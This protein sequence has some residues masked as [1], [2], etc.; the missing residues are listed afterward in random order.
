MSDKKILLAFYSGVGSTRTIAEVL[1]I[2]L[3]DHN[4]RI[5]L[6]DID[7]NTDASIIEKYDFLIIGTPTHHCYPP[8]T[9]SEFIDKIGN[10]SKPINIFLFATYGLYVGNNL[11]KIAKSLLNKNIHTVGFTGFRSPAT[12]ATLMFPK[13]IRMMYKY[14]SNAK[15]KIIKTVA[16]ID[17]LIQADNPKVKMPFYK[18]YAPL[19]WLP[20]KFYTA[21]KFDRDFKPNIRLVSA[22]W[23]GEEIDCPRNCWE[24]VDNKPKYRKD[25]CEF[26]LRCIHR[27]PN[28]AVIYSIDMQDRQRLDIELYNQLKKELL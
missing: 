1:Q 5:D 10:Q 14:E 13:I 21:R 22:R 9:V 3:Q 24:M 15:D 17:R 4:H 23:N 16:E 20:N 11:R 6:L 8:K 19:D 28:K 26:C 12:D 27:T 7:V 18:W 25:N 2:R